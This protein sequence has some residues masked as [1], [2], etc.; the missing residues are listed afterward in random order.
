M[1][2]KKIT[3]LQAEYTNTEVIMGSS[4]VFFII[5]WTTK[6][7][8]FLA[9]GN[10][11]LERVIHFI[12]RY[13]PKPTFVIKNQ[14]GIFLVDAYDDSM[15]ICS[16]YFEKELRPWLALPTSRDL[17]IDI[18]A[19]RGIYSILACTQYGY[20]KALAFE[21]NQE[22]ATVLKE[23]LTLNELAEKVTIHTVALGEKMGEA[24]FTVDPLHKGGGRIEDTHRN[25]DTSS[26]VSVATLDSI[27]DPEEKTAVSF[28]KI[29][30]EGY[31][32]AVLKGMKNTLSHMQKGSVLMIE[33][34]EAAMIE[35]F[36]TRFQFKHSTTNKHDHLFIKH[37]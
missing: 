35:T 1:F 29:D 14:G 12:I 18:G 37:A 25:I 3:A 21:P 34:T 20:A 32:I 10:T 17:F 31:E 9:H 22:V 28:I 33:S 24:P 27:L 19:N 23:N 5:F 11:L 13:L 8:S 6:A 36:L 4:L 26:T 15:T 2:Y 30:T 16:G 7:F